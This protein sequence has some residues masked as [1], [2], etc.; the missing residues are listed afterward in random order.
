M[1]TRKRPITLALVVAACLAHP[2]Q[3]QPSPVLPEADVRREERAF[4][5]ARG[6]RYMEQ[7]CA[8]TTF[9]G[10]TGFPV[11]RCTYSVRDRRAGSKTAT[12]ILLDATPRQ[13]AQWVV[14]ACM[15]ARHTSAVA[16]TSR[17]RRQIIGQSGAQFPVAGIVLEDMD[18][19]GV[20]N[21]FV[22]RDG[23][24]C[25]VMGVT[26]GSTALVTP[27]LVRRSLNARIVSVGRFA[28]I[29]STTR[30]QYRAN[31]GAV[32]VGN[33]TN[34]KAAW[35]TVVRDLYQKAWNSDRN[36]LLIAWV[37]AN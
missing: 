11:K 26:N 15:E 29:A 19:D 23:V 31:G 13:L 25:G 32:D 27:E 33:S 6:A 17:L 22:F 10:W 28:R 12:V 20:Q 3:A 35:L 21:I 34:R 16:C 30:E 8:D 14:R 5:D 36:E 9:E 18:G 2:V 1:L 4:E 37:R 24:T 7:N